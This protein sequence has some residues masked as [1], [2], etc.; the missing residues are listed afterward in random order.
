MYWGMVMPNGLIWL[1]LLKGKQ[2]A[3]KYVSLLS[4]YAVP[5]MKLNYINNFYFVQDNAAIHTAKIVKKYF[6]RTGLAVLGWP[7][8]S[9]DLNIMENIWKMI[10]DQVYSSNQPKNNEELKKRVSAAVD[11]I[12]HR[13]RRNV[14]N[15]FCD[16]RRRLTKVLIMNGNIIN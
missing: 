6:D 4:T 11:N 1:I 9:P 7:A 3:Q 5:I 15:L 2:N 10:S 13:M 16:L 8:K 12:N 14:Q